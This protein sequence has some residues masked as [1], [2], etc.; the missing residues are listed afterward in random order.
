MEWLDAILQRDDCSADGKQQAQ[1]RI[2]E[3][4][5][6]GELAV[7][8]SL[9][10]AE[11]FELTDCARQQPRD[12]CIGEPR[13]NACRNAD[14]EAGKHE[15]DNAQRPVWLRRMERIAACLPR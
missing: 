7:A 3:R 11:V 8:H 15:K 1:R 6:L 9:E 2:Q 4:L 13:K 12:Q 5:Q 10:E 14:H